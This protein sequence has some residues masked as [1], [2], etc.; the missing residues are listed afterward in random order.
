TNLIGPG[1]ITFDPGNA[2][3]L[4]PLSRPLYILFDRY[5]NASTIDTGNVYV[6]Q[7]SGSAETPISVTVEYFPGS[8]TVTIVPVDG[9]FPDNAAFVLT[10]SNQIMDV[11]SPINS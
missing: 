3:Q 6:N 1:S 11:S 2:S 5:M 4:T 9:E 10:L 7:V 8:R